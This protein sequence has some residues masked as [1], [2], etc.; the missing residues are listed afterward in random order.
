ML[1]VGLG[2]I[3][4]SKVEIARWDNQGFLSFDGTDDKAELNVDA[5]FISSVAGEGSPPIAKAPTFVVPKP[6]KADRAVA[7]SPTSVQEVPSHDSVAAVTEPVVPAYTI[8]KVCI[9]LPAKARLAVF[10]FVVSVQEEP[11]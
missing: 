8:P 7:T 5:A 9:P 4:S 2:G 3:K 10:I 11:S 6:A 1:G